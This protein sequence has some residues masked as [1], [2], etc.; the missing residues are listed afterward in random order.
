MSGRTCPREPEILAAT[1]RGRIDPS[2]GDHVRSCPDCR[3]AVAAD[4][5]LTLLA[6]AEDARPFPSATVLRLEAELRLEE[7]RLARRA[8][9]LVGLHAGALALSLVLLASI[10]V[11]ELGADAQTSTFGGA[12]TV[13]AIVVVL[14]SIW[15]LLR[16]AEESAVPL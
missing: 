4:R 8:R 9:R 3:S 12:G 5:A 11:S 14:I 15:N 13:C 7:Q 1:R 10:R 6:A 2:I 16:T